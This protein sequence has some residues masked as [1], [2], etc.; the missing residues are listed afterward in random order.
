[1]KYLLILLTT[2]LLPTF[3][4]AQSPATGFHISAVS[5]KSESEHGYL[6][7]YTAIP[8]SK[9]TFEATPDGFTARYRVNVEISRLDSD[10]KPEHV[11]LAPV[12]EQSVTEELHANTIAPNRTDLSTYSVE[13]DSG[14]YLVSATLTDLISSNVYFQSISKHQRD[15]SPP[16]TISDLVLLAGFDA[17]SQSIIPH[18]STDVNAGDHQIYYEV[19]SDTSQTLLVHRVLTSSPPF[20]P[21]TWTDTLHVNAGRHQHIAHIPAG[22]LQF[23]Q[24][25]IA[26]TLQSLNGHIIDQSMYPVNVRWNGVSS[27]LEDLNGAIEQL[28]Y[29]AKSSELRTLKSA[30]TFLEQKKLFE[31]FWKKRDPTPET[32]RNEAMEEHY[33]RVDYSNQTF[34][35]Q[36]PGW[37]SDRGHVFILHGHPDEVQRQTFRY[38]NQP[39][40]IWYFF[41]L[42]RQ[43]MFVD[44][45]GFGDFELVLPVWDERTRI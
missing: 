43:F 19:Y 28:V 25:D 8:Y 35:Q 29:I 4:Q 39:W 10:K 42:G 20:P 41:E 11:M 44:Q 37:Q 12:W 32:I 22:N 9:L 13:L 14:K 34:G 33:Y 2:S 6:N 30:E 17:K 18:L 38:N 45:T 40:E 23:R 15:F 27:Y 3:L 36:L 5:Y 1:M 31:A 21:H 7:L 24:Y 26:V 16:V